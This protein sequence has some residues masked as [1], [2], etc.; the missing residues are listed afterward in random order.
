LVKKVEQAV[1][2]AVALFLLGLLRDFS[3]GLNKFTY[4]NET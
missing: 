3:H 2:Y 4:V 1:Q